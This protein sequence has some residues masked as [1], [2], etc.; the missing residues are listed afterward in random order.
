MKAKGS[1]NPWYGEGLQFSC[2]RCGSC[3]TG[4][5]GFV[6]VTPQ[7]IGRLADH[8][9][10]TLDQ[11]GRTNV[12]QVGERYSLVERPGGDCIF[13]DHQAGCTVYEARPTQCRTWPFWAENLATPA[14][15]SRM[16]R[17]CPGAGQGDWFAL[18]EIE[19]AAE[20]TPS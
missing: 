13:W 12:R 20:R 9:D 6:W 11:F 19:A 14:S 8:L 2:T 5:P 3:C 16:A 1:G 15:W 17:S 4:A 10:M 18:E 7:E